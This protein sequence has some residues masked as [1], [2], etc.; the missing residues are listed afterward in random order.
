MNML[1][2]PAGVF[3]STIT[4]SSSAAHAAIF[5]WFTDNCP[6]LAL[7]S[8]AVVNKSNIVQ[9]LAGTVWEASTKFVE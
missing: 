6:R 8:G 3:E 1:V 9:S 2:S 4:P 5:V 7:S